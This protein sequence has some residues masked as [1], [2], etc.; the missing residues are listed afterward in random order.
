MALGDRKTLL[1]YLPEV[2]LG[3]ATPILALYLCQQALKQLDPDAGAKADAQQKARAASSRLQSIFSNAHEPSTEED[4]YDDEDKS[5]DE[6]EDGR[7]NNPRRKQHHPQE[8]LV[9]T[10]REQT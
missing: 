4:R 2:L 10:P 1:S 7:P 6:D 5:S 9:L 8:P 3:L